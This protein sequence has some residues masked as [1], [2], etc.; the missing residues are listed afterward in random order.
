MARTVRKIFKINLF[1][2][3]R[4]ILPK[5]KDGWQRADKTNDLDYR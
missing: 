2:L 4:L 5:P 3:L 1:Y